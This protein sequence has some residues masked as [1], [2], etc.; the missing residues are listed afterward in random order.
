M[1]IGVAVVHGNGI[2]AV[3]VADGAQLPAD[4]VQCLLPADFLPLTVNF[5]KGFAQSLGVFVHVAKR[6]RFGADR[7]F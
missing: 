7:T 6:L 2:F 4:L 3:F 1:A 5:F